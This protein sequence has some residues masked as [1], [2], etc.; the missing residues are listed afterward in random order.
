MATPQP[1]LARSINRFL[2]FLGV[3]H[4][5]GNDHWLAGA[6]NV[7][8]QRQSTASNEAILY[9]GAFKSSSKSTAVLSTVNWK[10]GRRSCV[11]ASNSGACHSQACAPLVQ[12]VQGLAIP[13]TA[14][15]LEIFGVGV[16]GYCVRRISLQ[17]DRRQPSWP[18]R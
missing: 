8:D 16:Q 17:L 13:E 3:S 1:A 6:G 9:T 5:S 18:L 2:N 10:T 12:F 4:A 15:N 7:L 11:H 14:M